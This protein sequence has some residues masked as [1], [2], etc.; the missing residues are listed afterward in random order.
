MQVFLHV[1]DDLCLS[2]AS[3]GRSGCGS[4][5][6]CSHLDGDP[7]LVNELLNSWDIFLVVVLTNPD[8]LLAF[9]TLNF[10]ICFPTSVI[11]IPKIKTKPTEAG[12]RTDLRPL[13]ECHP[14]EPG[15][16]SRIGRAVINEKTV[17]VPSLLQLE[18][19]PAVTMKLSAR[20][21]WFELRRGAGVT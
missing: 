12:G 18:T 19:N 7:K 13:L 5:V 6:S 9:L 3:V 16:A 4:S 20:M 2:Q 14:L 17:R 15:T 11:S 21:I 1:S 10:W 8:V